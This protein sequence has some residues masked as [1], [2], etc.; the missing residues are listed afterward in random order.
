MRQTYAQVDLSAYRSNV[1]ALKQAMGPKVLLMAVVKADA[2]GHGLAPIARAAQQA[3]ADAL[4]VALAEEGVCLRQ[5]GLTLPILVLAGL[6]ADSSLQAVLH[7]LTLTVHTPQ[8]LD[9]A[10]QAAA[11]LGK[12]AQVHLKIDTGMNRIGIKDQAELQAM[13]SHLNTLPQLR[14]TGAFTHFAS[15]DELSSNQTSYQLAQFLALSAL[16]PPGI[17]LH[18]SGSSALLTRPDARLNMV[19]AGISLY[20]YSPV[21]TAVPLMPVLSWLAEITHVKQVPAG[22]PISYGATH[23]TEQQT[24]VA[25]LAVGYGDGYARSLSG[26]AQVLVNSRRCPVL[27]R[28]CMDQIM[29]DVTQAGLV[30]PGDSA[31]LLGSMG[32]ERILADE[33][34][35]LR[36]TISYEV[37]LGISARVP[38]VY[39]HDDQQ[40]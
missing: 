8:H 10:A 3:G 38:R 9:S 13:L 26:Q 15:A 30:S 24:K 32:Q 17:I 11:Q 31:V 37:L 7:E 6:N 36:G 40:G 35:R 1:K 25:T 2:Y 29:V 5:A 22:E 28:V 27:G 19:R 16:L 14:L 12:S 39:L 18:T 20:G 4:A 34:A 21:V 23:R 33:L